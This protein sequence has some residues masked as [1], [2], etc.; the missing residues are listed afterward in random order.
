MHLLFN[1]VC[2]VMG[3]LKKQIST[4]SGYVYNVYIKCKQILCLDLRPIPKISNY[5]NVNI[6]KSSK[7]RNISGPKNVRLRGL[8]LY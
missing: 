2:D 7:S 8:N 6:P 5:V 1:W 4:T 3:R